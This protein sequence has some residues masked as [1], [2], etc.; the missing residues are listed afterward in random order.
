MPTDKALVSVYI[1]QEAKEKLEVWAKE[2]DR[3]LSYIVGRLIADAIE[4]RE[5]KKKKAPSSIGSDEGERVAAE[6]A[7][8]KRKSS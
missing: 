8:S 3:S 1:P 6:K 4:L 2:E 5:S 7:K